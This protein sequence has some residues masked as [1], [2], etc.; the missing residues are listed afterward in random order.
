MKKLIVSLV[1]SM[2]VFFGLASTAGACF[3]LFY[4][5]EMPQKPQE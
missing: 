1:I 5:A 2:L 3:W 4:Q